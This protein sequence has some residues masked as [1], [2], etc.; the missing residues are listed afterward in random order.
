MTDYRTIWGTSESN[1]WIISAT[2]LAFRYD[3]AKWGTVPSPPDLVSGTLV[4]SFGIYTLSGNTDGTFWAAGENGYT[5]RWN[6][7]ALQSFTTHALEQL[8]GIWMGPSGEA[9]VVGKNGVI[10][11]HR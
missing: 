1:V 10:L 3:G 6:G 11:H 8:N 4:S 9:W 7:N 2:S 5:M